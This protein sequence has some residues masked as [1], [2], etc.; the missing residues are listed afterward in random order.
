MTR[1]PRN[2]SARLSLG[3]ASALLLGFAISPHSALA[4]GF[5]ACPHQGGDVGGRQRN[6]QG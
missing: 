6:D 5:D 4:R 2:D 1:L 3:A